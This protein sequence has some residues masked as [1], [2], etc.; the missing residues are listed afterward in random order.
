MKNR[1]TQQPRS[2][3]RCVTCRLLVALSVSLI[4]AMGYAIYVGLVP[5]LSGR[6]PEKKGTFYFNIKRNY[7]SSTRVCVYTCYRRTIV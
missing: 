2:L 6:V 4:R 1:A 3:Q 5:L 7:S